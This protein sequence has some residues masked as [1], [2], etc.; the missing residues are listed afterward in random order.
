MENGRILLI[1]LVIFVLYTWLYYRYTQKN[2]MDTPFNPITMIPMA[3]GAIW[4]VCTVFNTASVIVSC[5]IALLSGV[6][7]YF[8][9][10][11]R[12]LRTVLYTL[13]QITAVSSVVFIVI[14]LLYMFVTAISGRRRR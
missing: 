10:G 8:A 12:P 1:V 3:G 13:W 4:M 14:W 9:T 6:M 2:D 11:K 5:V 7:N